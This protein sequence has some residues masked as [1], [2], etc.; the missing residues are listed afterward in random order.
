MDDVKIWREDDGTVKTNIPWSVRHHS[1]MGFEVGYE[2]SGPADLALNILNHFV[3]PGREIDWETESLIADDADRDDAPEKC[4]EGTVSRFAW[5]NHQ[6][7][8]RVF[9]ATLPKSGGII[10]ADDINNWIVA[11]R[12][13]DTSDSCY[14]EVEW[15]TDPHVQK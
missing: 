3:P 7:F 2:G 8:K 15:N 14:R 6:D 5:M 4:W 11:R 10:R 12:E 13:E 1:P 9:I